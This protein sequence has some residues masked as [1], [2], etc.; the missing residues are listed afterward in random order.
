MFIKQLLAGATC[1]A[2]SPAAL[3][4]AA[5]PQAFIHTTNTMLTW[6]LVAQPQTQMRQPCLH[7]RGGEVGLALTLV[8]HADAAPQPAAS[9][10]IVSPHASRTPSVRPESACAAGEPGM[11]T[12][13]PFTHQHMGMQQ[14]ILALTP[15]TFTLV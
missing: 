9:A 10:L 8:W 15:A 1:T 14:L 11:L 12:P 4:V 6:T 2:A 5:P 7:P 13:H 3:P